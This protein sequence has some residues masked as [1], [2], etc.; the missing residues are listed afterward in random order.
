V[1]K[2]RR[3]VGALMMLAGLGMV[4]GGITG[5][6][7]HEHVATVAEL[8]V[9]DT[10]LTKG[11]LLIAGGVFACVAGGQVFRAARHPGRLSRLGRVLLVGGYLLVAVGLA[12]AAK[13]TSVGGFSVGF[14]LQVVGAV[15]VGIGGSAAR[16]DPGPPS[17]HGP[18]GH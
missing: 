16:P 13:Y 2:G 9:Y 6:A 10:R 4:A 7:G 5:A 11:V 14:G 1:A 12:V 3:L 18:S 17:S 8:E 15:A